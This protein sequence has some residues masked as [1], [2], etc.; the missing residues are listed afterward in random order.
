MWLLFLVKFA[1]VQCVSAITRYGL[2]KQPFVLT[3]A[4]A[5]AAVAFAGELEQEWTEFCTVAIC[6]ENHMNNYLLC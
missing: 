2:F 3:I 6:L 5:V 4:F 1:P